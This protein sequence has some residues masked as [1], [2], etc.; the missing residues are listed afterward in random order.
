MDWPFFNRMDIST[1]AE[2]EATE[3]QWPF[4]PFHLWLIVGHC[5]GVVS[6]F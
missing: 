2:L 6:Y 1:H 4:L 5:I 3:T